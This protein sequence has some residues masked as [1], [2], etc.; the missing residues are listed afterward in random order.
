MFLEILNLSDP[1][2]RAALL[3]RE[4]AGRPELRERVESLLEAHQR[5]GDFLDVPALRQ[6]ENDRL[7][8]ETKIVPRKGDVEID[9]SF[10]EPTTASDSLGKLH[11][12]EIREM[13]GH[14]GCGVVLRALDTKLERM[15]AIKVMFPELAATSPA[16][17]RFI[18]ET[19]ATAAIRHANVVT[20]C[21]VEEKPIPFLVM[22]FIDGE[23]LQQRINRTGPI[24]AVEVLQIGY[25]IACGLTAAHQSGL[26]H[27]DIKPANILVENGSNQLK[28]TDFGLARSVD[29][30]SITQS[31][32]IA[33]TSLY[34][35]PEQA[36]ALDIDARSDLFSLGSVLYVLG[37]GRP[38]FRAGSTLAVMRR[39][40]EDQPRPLQS[41]I[42]EFPTWLATI[43][44]KLHAKDPADRFTESKDLVGLLDD[45]RAQLKKQG[46]VELPP[47]VVPPPD[48]QQEDEF[49][50]E[51][52]AERASLPH[53]STAKPSRRARLWQIFA[54]VL[55]AVLVSLGAT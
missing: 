40:V 2:E 32:M 14:G 54:L 12:Y 11:H 41:I 33:G 3:D 4:C 6:I 49:D 23:T 5:S 17:K 34:M 46:H 10:L 47:H 50:A 30:A 52:T 7:I 27:R 20:I 35:S 44:A 26:I 45:C 37:S 55:L 31:G 9:L 8:D 42:P 51:S 29:D 21:T 1:V 13:I 25:E 28:I 39:V 16:R 18:R 24:D 19:Q 53:N 36:Q 48:P 15:V 22:E 38:P 43:I